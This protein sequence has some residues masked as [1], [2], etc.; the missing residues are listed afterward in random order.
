MLPPLA[1]RVLDQVLAALEDAG[2]HPEIAPQHP[3]MSTQE[4]ADFLGVSRP[5]VVRLVS[6]GILPHRLDGRKRFVPTAAVLAYRQRRADSALAQALTDLARGEPLMTSADVDR[7][8]RRFT[9]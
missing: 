1:Q 9:A 8:A 5:T 6:A 7:A 2:R 3:D 4:A